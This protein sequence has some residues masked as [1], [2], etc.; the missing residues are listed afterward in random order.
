MAITEQTYAVKDFMESF[1]GRPGSSY[2][3]DDAMKRAIAWACGGTAGDRPRRVRVGAGDFYFNEDNILHPKTAGA[4]N[5]YG[6]HFYGA[7]HNHTRFRLRRTE[8]VPKWFYNADP[9]WDATKGPGWNRVKFE[10][11][12]FRSDIVNDDVVYTD[13][14]YRADLNGFNVWASATAPPLLTGMAA[15]NDKGFVFEN[16]R[17][18]GLEVPHS[19]TGQSNTDTFN[20]YSCWWH[21]C[22]PIIF[23]NDQVLLCTFYS[24][25][26]W[27]ANDM[28]HIKATV[29]NGQQGKGGGGSIKV[30]DGDM[31]HHAMDG[32]ADDHYTL[33]IDD[34]ASFYRNF[35][36]DHCKWEFRGRHSKLL[37]WDG[38][39]SFI[40]GSQVLFTNGCDLSVAQ[41]G[42]G[43]GGD[44]GSDTNGVREFIKLGPHRR[45][46]FDNAILPSQ[47]A[48]AFGSVN[49]GQIVGFGRQG[50]ID[51]IRCQLPWEM[52]SGVAGNLVD[53]NLYRRLSA[54]ITRDSGYGRVTA[55]DC[56]QRDATTSERTAM[57]DWDYGGKN[58]VRGE[59]GTPAPTRYYFK[60]EQQSWP[61]YGVTERTL[62]LME[63]QEIIGM[64]IDK[65]AGGT[66]SVSE[67]SYAITNDAKTETYIET[68][69]FRADGN[70]RAEANIHTDPQLFP[71]KI[72][73]V[74]TR[75]QRRL[76][77][78]QRVN[79]AY[80]AASGDDTGGAWVDVR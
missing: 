50:Q 66:L 12:W 25:H 13:P 78:I 2:D 4:A 67:I 35:T 29:G 70:H 45:V 37:H 3:N 76:R 68:G 46:V 58:A 31:I 42:A 28:F 72:P 64:G 41:Q 65:P 16:C 32:D 49:T 61:V 44:E 59:S 74:A 22:G 6:P 27:C 34:G 63:G 52:Y 39:S 11:I 20:N 5:G 54:R 48:V 33:R 77:L 14:E 8:G 7:S 73:L 24:C 53:E 57:S 40:T 36:F 30:V 26:F 18:N 9:A 69:P 80:N 62:L 51:L 47:F 75:T 60:T 19:F 10:N 15:G 71:I 17:F 43:Y 1:G 79:H 56:G 23:D 55:R 21:N 38:N